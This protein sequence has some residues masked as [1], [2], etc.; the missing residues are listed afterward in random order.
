MASL[1]MFT[2]FHRGTP[3]DRFHANGQR[4]VIL[5]HDEAPRALVTPVDILRT[6][7]LGRSYVAVPAGSSPHSRVALTEEERAGLV[8]PPDPPK[9][10]T[11]EPLGT[12]GFRPRNTTLGGFTIEHGG[13]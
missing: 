5:E 12:L 9:D 10:G 4:V 7:G 11:L 2:R 1:D 3:P 6:D 8:V 13:T